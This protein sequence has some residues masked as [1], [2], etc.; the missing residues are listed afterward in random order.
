MSGERSALFDDRIRMPWWDE[1]TSMV[2][3]YRI[4]P[5]IGSVHLVADRFGAPFVPI[6]AGTMRALGELCPSLLGNSR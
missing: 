3:V 1:E 4:D 2:G 6:R 5:D